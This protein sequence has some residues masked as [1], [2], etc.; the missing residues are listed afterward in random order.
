MARN[1]D[2]R[3]ET[4]VPRRG[5]HI[6]PDLSSVRV[7]F[8]IHRNEPKLPGSDSGLGITLSCTMRTL[9]KHGVDAQSWG[10]QTFEQL[11]LKLENEEFRSERKITHVIISTPNFLSPHQFAELALR[12]HEID[13]VMLA[14]TGLAY[15]CIDDHGPQKIRELLHLERSTHNIKVAGNSPR[16]EWFGIYG[17]QPLLLPNLY[18]V[19]SFVSPVHHRRDHDPLRIGCFGE[20]RP[21]KNQ[22]V[23]AEAALSIAKKMGV[24]LELFVNEDRWNQTWPYSQARQE[25]F[26][27][28]RWAKIIKVPWAPWSRFREI[29]ATMDLLISVSFDE[30]FNIV[31]SDG[32]AEGVPSVVGNCIEWAPRSWQTVEPFDPASAAAIGMALLHSRESAVHEGRRALVDFVD[33]GVQRWIRYLTA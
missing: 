28:L 29:V 33:A 13:F 4:V 20:N 24:Y 2:F 12:W 3:H 5:H 17:V 22:S 21:W 25:L 26:D 27:G 16:F 6:A 14:H 8:V 15:M 23:G 18:D 1:P 30:T 31:T 9:R 7:I 32:V 11:S 10:V 19:D